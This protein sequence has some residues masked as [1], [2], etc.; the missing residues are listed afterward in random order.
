MC[1][2]RLRRRAPPPCWRDVSRQSGIPAGAAIR[3]RRIAQGRD[4]KTL[5]RFEN[6]AIRK[7]RRRL[8]HRRE[9]MRRIDRGAQFLA[10]WLESVAAHS[11]E[12]FEASDGPH[13]AMV[14]PASLS[15]DT[16]VLTVPSMLWT[17]LY[18]DSEQTRR[19]TIAFVPPCSASRSSLAVRD[20]AALGRPSLSCR[21]CFPPLLSPVPIEQELFDPIRVEEVV[22]CHVPKHDEHRV[23]TV[24]TVVGRLAPVGR[25]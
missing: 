3:C 5:P 18:V 11:E 16:T 21:L 8:A 15:C 6:R 19:G 2:R 9:G 1:P 23:M 25:R 14:A 22:K 13:Q 7:H 24:L 20:D 12:V 17:A 10:L 4:L